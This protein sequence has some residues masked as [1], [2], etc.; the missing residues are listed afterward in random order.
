M[1]DVTTMSL[2]EFFEARISEDEALAREAVV[3]DVHPSV[4][5]E[6]LD[7]FAGDAIIAAWANRHSPARVLAECAAKRAIVAL[8]QSFEAR[9]YECLT[10]GT[11]GEY[12]VDWP[13][14]TLRALALPYADHADYL[15][16]WRP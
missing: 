14:D 6:L 11:V 7:V 9:G 8:H 1:T 4:H 16:E 10:C 13:C 5:D 2:T 12:G 3:F 15:E